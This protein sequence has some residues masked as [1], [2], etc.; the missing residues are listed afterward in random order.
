MSNEQSSQFYVGWGT[1]ALI[2]GN[3]A[4]IKGRNG[5]LWFVASLFGGPIV[6]AALCFVRPDPRP[7]A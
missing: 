4:Q 6:T 7:R 2:N 1:L 3:L 5:L